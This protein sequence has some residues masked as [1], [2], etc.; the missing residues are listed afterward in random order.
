MSRPFCLAVFDALSSILGGYLSLWSWLKSSL[1][2]SLGGLGLR[3]AAFHA[4]LPSSAQSVSRVVPALKALSSTVGWSDWS[5]LSDVDVPLSQC[6]LSRS[7]D[8]VQEPSH[9][10]FLMLE[11]GCLW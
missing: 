7:I 4:L 5:S 2:V 3:Q 8:Q 6:H 11:T 10:P 9:L 1:L